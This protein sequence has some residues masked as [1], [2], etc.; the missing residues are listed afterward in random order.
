MQTLDGF[1]MFLLKEANALNQM[2]GLIF[3]AALD[4]CIRCGQWLYCSVRPE[5]VRA[6]ISRGL[7]QDQKWASCM[8]LEKKNS[9]RSASEQHPKLTQWLDT[10]GAWELVQGTFWLFTPLPSM[11][12]KSTQ[13][14]IGTDHTFFPLGLPIPHISCHPKHNFYSHHLDLPA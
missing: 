7:S 12:S 2:L 4:R 1:I 10:D 13:P 14:T 6:R 9:P 5:E 8:W 3:L 11:H